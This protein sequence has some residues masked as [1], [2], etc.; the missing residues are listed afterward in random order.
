MICD[1]VENPENG[2]RCGSYL[3]SVKQGLRYRRNP[4]ASRT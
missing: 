2:A 3:K 4:S 1:I